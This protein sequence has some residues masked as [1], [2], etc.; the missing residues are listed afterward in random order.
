MQPSTK[1]VLLFFLHLCFLLGNK[2]LMQDSEFT[3][4]I[5]KGRLPAV[6]TI[7]N[8]VYYAMD[9][10]GETPW[11]LILTLLST[12]S[13][14]PAET[15]LSHSVPSCMRLFIYLPLLDFIQL[16]S[17]HLWNLPRH[18]VA[19]LFSKS[20]FS[21]TPLSKGYEYCYWRYWIV[22]A[23]VFISEEHHCE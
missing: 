22:L 8:T 21:T 1:F 3:F 9:F 5:V 6:S 20:L 4:R 17:G 16:L 18:F 15:A 10:Q 23:L 2:T 11:Q 7:I 14:A 13:P 12:G 19:V